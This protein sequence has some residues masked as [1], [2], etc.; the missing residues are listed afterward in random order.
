MRKKINDKL[1][2]SRETLGTL[3]HL[4]LFAA[5]GGGTTSTTGESNSN[6]TCGTCFGPSCNNNP[7]TTTG[8]SA[9]C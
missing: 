6:A 5:Q 3:T 1:A 8:T 2:L 7:T 9:C 4:D